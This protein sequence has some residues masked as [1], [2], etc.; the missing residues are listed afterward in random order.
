MFGNFH[1]AD[2]IA[3]H[4]M[5]IDIE[6]RLELRD[7]TITS[8]RDYVSTLSTR[9]RDRLRPQFS[10]FAQTLR[11]GIE[12]EN[13][14]DGLIMF[15]FNDEIKIGWYE[16]KWPRVN[17]PDYRWD[18]VPPGHQMSH[19]SEQILKQHRWQDTLALWEMFVNEGLDGFQSPPYSTF[20]SSCLWHESAFNFMQQKG[21]VFQR[22]TTGDLKIMLERDC[23]SFYS[24]IFDLLSCRKGKK[25]KLARGQRSVRLETP[26][27]NGEDFLEI[28]LPNIDSLEFDDEVNS[29]M[30]KRNIAGY[31][32]MDL[33]A[34][35][36]L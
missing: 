19:F 25:I 2:F 36:K 8:E 14:V 26:S 21:L 32:L 1:L 30:K 29:F 18:R 17:V 6:C 23:L 7:G 28:P 12:T 34:I 35:R 5:A 10:C 4:C 3:I 27:D 13:G 11:Q 20:G 22:W 33:D 16:A 31:L 15:R 24:I 9:I